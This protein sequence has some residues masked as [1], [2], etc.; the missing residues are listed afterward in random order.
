MQAASDAAAQ[1]Q[2]AEALQQ[3]VTLVTQAHQKRE[4]D[5][6]LCGQAAGHQLDAVVKKK[7]AE[8]LQDKV[9]SC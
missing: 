2:A 4:S 9:S 1:K 3:A 5:K 6:Q 7:E 8:S